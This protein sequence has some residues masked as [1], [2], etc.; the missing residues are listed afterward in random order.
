MAHS[1][2]FDSDFL[3]S[4][5][6]VY[7]RH[8][9]P[10]WLP[11]PTRQRH[12]RPQSDQYDK[13]GFFRCWNSSSHPAKPADLSAFN[14]I[15]TLDNKNARLRGEMQNFTCL[16]TL[17]VVFYHIIIEITLV[18]GWTSALE[19]TSLNSPAVGDL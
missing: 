11:A 18:N 15:L 3:N 4:Q 2:I 12:V 1:F 5:G 17:I 13:L 7:I 9:L 16:K 14:D 8:M 10:S 19:K 6:F